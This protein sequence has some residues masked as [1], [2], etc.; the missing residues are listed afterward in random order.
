MHLVTSLDPI[1]L[2]R[3]C[4]IA[5]GIIGLLFTGLT[6]RRR[7]EEGVI[8][9]LPPLLITGIAAYFSYFLFTP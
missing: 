2:G 5:L 9:V 4:V 3:I 6:I 8:A 7:K 1:L